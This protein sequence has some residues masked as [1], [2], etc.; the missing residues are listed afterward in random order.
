MR[1]LAY[2]VLCTALMTVGCDLGSGGPNGN[3]DSV[4]ELDD[5]NIA[6]ESPADCRPISTGDQCGPCKPCANAAVHVSDY[7]QYLADLDS[8]VCEEQEAESCIPC[9][10]P[11]VAC[12]SET[13]EL[14]I[15]VDQAPTATINE[16]EVY[17][18]NGTNSE[19]TTLDGTTV[20]VIRGTDEGS[21][22]IA[23]DETTF[24]LQFTFENLDAVPLHQP[25]NLA[26]DS[27][28]FDVDIAVGCFCAPNA[29]EPEYSLS[30]QVQFRELNADSAVGDLFS[31]VVNGDIPQANGGIYREDS[32][33]EL[34]WVD[35]RAP[36][37]VTPCL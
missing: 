3:A 25:I 7:S 27:L 34:D 21:C 33:L 24:Q 31:V 15:D 28:P 10:E 36:S 37:T 32:V 20:M 2:P 35:F 19:I 5:Y 1:V 23:D 6:C 8:I 4:I 29:G 18:L 12:I 13:C 11:A 22:S 9:L 26:D 16:S 30:G 17:S 14:T